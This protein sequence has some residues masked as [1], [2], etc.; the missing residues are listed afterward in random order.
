MGIGKG[1]AV[2]RW[3]LPVILVIAWAMSLWVTYWA[4]FGRAF[5]IMHAN[6]ISEVHTNAMVAKSLQKSMATGD[7]DRVKNYLEQ[8]IAMSRVL[9][10]EGEAVPSM[11]S[12]EM[13]F[14][15]VWPE[16]FFQLIQLSEVQLKQAKERA[17]KA[18]ANEGVGAP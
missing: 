16:H 14:D 2:R 12:K 11:C 7:V 4:G 3:V 6:W 13:I 17:D 10:G 15:L 8:N 5:F 18:A 1:S 9:H